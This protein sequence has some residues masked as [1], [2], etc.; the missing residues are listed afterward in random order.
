MVNYSMGEWS[1]KVGEKGEEIVGEFLHLIGWGNA[2]NN[3][4]L[5]CIKGKNHGTS[6]SPKKTHGIDYLF[7]YKSQLLE[8]TKPP[9]PL[10]HRANG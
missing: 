10:Q 3:I 1:K 7:S 9:R 2:Q 8:R 4:T 5:D 6:E